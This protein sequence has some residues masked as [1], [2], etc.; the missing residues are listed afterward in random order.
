MQERVRAVEFV[1]KRA[2]GLQAVTPAGADGG[3]QSSPASTT[4]PAVPRHNAGDGLSRQAG[5]PPP[6]ARAARGGPQGPVSEW[7]SRRRRKQ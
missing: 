4:A 7:R 1:L 5:A 3:A 2:A 6:A